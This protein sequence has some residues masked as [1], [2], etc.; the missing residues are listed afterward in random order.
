LVAASLLASITPALAAPEAWDSKVYNPKPLE[1]DTVLPMPCG[2]SMVFRPVQVPGGDAYSDYQITVGGQ[3]QERGFA[4]GSHPAYVAGSFTD[5]KAKARYYL[6]GKYEITEAQYDA[7]MNDTCPDSK[8]SQAKRLSKGGVSWFDAIAFSDKY[9][10]WLRQNALKSLPSE[11]GEAGY[12]RLPTEVE[13]EFAARGGIKVSPAEFNERLFPMTGGLN[14]YAW[15]AGTQSANGKPNLT[16]QLEPNP[17]GLFDVLGN[18][19]EIIFEPF[20][21][22]RLDRLHGQSGSFV[23]RG[24]NYMTSAEDMRSA[25]RQEVPFYEG[26]TPRRS[27]TTGFRVV[28]AAPVLTSQK[29]LQTLKDEWSKLGAV[30][31][32]DNAA[33]AKTSDDPLEDLALLAKAS[34]DPATKARLEKVQ[35]TLRANI[36]ARDDQRDRAA[37]ASLR[38]GAFLGRKLSDDA[39]AIDALAKVYKGRVET[40]GVDD[41]RAKSYKEELDHEQTVMD[42]NLRYYADTLI[43]TAEDY[44]SDT[45]KHQR[46]ILLVEL[47][48]MGLAELK[49]YVDQYFTHIAAYQKDKKVARIQWLGDWNKLQAP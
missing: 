8:P 19:D 14:K 16:G 4:E 6:I 23:V 21:L 31:A 42:G 33:P 7:V 39:H 22:N 5:S 30:S 41:P 44:S 37:K 46:E 45:L 38:L 3:D 35:T 9:S 27:K 34:T 32:A 43:R 29:R 10:Q 2:G 18:M 11:D 28:V 47:Q 15:F 26:A 12:V 20:R 1:G 13:W 40:G 25:D 24:G 49:P 36:A 17:L 48:G